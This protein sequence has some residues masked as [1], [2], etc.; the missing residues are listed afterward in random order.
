MRMITESIDHYLLRCH[1]FYSQRCAL[2]NAVLCLGVRSVTLSVLLGG[3]DYSS[4]V[5]GGI[6]RALLSFV[7]NT[8]RVG[9][10]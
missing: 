2:T 4:E 7:K 5:R 9:D 1:R 8:G 10:L 3:G 6:F